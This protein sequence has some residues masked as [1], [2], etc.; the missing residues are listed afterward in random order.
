[1]NIFHI[2]SVHTR[3]DIR[4]FKKECVSL[5]QAGHTVTLIVCDGLGGETCEGVRIIDAGNYNK[6]PRLKR[7]RQG[8]KA[9]LKKLLACA[10][11]DVVHFHDPELLS[12]GLKLKRL[13]K[14][15][16]FDSHEDVPAQILD[17][18]WI[19]APLRKVVSA[20]YKQ[21][22]TRAVGRFDAVV[23]ATPHIAD[24]F[25]GR[26]KKIV[27]VNNYPRLDD[28]VFQTK[29]FAERERIVCYAGGINELR[30]EK[31]MVAAMEKVD[32]TLILAGDHD[33]M[34]IQNTSGGGYVST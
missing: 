7:A 5:A 32:G 33:K 12:C 4:I 2:T 20:G 18:H 19:P 29:P 1:M 8:S 17:K 34:T 15:V 22:E 26:A 27:V 28:I 25:E 30:G 9:I 13:G 6:L 23:A 16:I 24:Q 31:V 21:Y 11:V 10:D 14:K 3:Y